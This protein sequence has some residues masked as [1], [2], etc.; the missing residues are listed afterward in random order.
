MTDIVAISLI[1]AVP[2]TLA[3]LAS[4]VNTLI[5]QKHGR[6]IMEQKHTIETLEKNTNSIKDALVKVT[7]EEAFN[8]GLKIGQEGHQQ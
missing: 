1:G 8:R 2:A 6:Q 5:L 4:V 7:G 3:A